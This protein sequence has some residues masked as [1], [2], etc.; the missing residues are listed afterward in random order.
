MYIY[1]IFC[2]NFLKYTFYNNAVKE[3]LFKGEN[4]AGSARFPNFYAAAGNLGCLGS[5]EL[6]EEVDI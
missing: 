1:N 2:Y 4:E 6:L 5:S 3:T